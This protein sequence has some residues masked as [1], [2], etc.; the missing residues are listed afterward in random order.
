[1]APLLNDKNDI[2]GGG[3]DIKCFRCNSIALMTGAGGNS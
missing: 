1:M 2:K 3:G